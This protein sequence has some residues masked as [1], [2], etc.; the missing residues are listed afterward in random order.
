M[1][2]FVG[3]NIG[4]LFCESE[5]GD[6]FLTTIIYNI[7]ILM[8]NLNTLCNFITTT[9]NIKQKKIQTKLFREI[10]I[11]YSIC[12]TKIQFALQSLYAS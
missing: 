1:L 12:K 2:Y 5:H 9:E 4:E 7:D 3:A 8:T 11:V 6:F 10:E